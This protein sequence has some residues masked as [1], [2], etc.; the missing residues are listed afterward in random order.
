MRRIEVDGVWVD[1]QGYQC[2]GCGRRFWVEERSNDCEN[3]L[4]CP[5]CEDFAVELASDGC[6]ARWT[7][8]R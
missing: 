4:W 5:V 7:P 3:E 6:L 2:V 1:V 8:P